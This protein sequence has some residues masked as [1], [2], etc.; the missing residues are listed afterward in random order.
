MILIVNIIPVVTMLSTG[1]N[2]YHIPVAAVVYF[3]PH[4]FVGP[5][6]FYYR[7][8]KTERHELWVAINGITCIS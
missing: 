7:L 5:P 6:C 1:Y 4:K 8:Y 3:P 2:G